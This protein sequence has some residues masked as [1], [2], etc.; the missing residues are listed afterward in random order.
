MAA[1]QR[2]ARTRVTDMSPA[3]LFLALR[4]ADLLGHVDLAMKPCDPHDPQQLW[5]FP[6]NHGLGYAGV[7]VHQSTKLCLMAGGCGDSSGTPLVLDECTAACLASKPLAGKFKLHHKSS[8]PLA[9]E[10]QFP[11][12]LVADASSA[13]PRVVLMEWDAKSNTHQQWTTAMPCEFAMARVFSLPFVAPP[14]CKSLPLKSAVPQTRARTTRCRSGRARTVVDTTTVPNCHLLHPE[15]LTLAGI[16]QQERESV[17][18]DS[19]HR[20]VSGGYPPFCP[21]E[22]CCLSVHIDVVPDGDGG[23]LLAALILSGAVTYLAGGVVVG[24]LSQRPTSGG[25]GSGIRRLAGS[26]PHFTQLEQLGGLCADGLQFTVGMALQRGQ[27][28]SRGGS[29]SASA[30]EP[31]RCGAGCPAGKKKA[32]SKEK[33]DRGTSSGSDKKALGKQKIAKGHDRTA[34]DGKS[35]GNGGESASAPP[36]PMDV[37]AAA[38]GSAAGGGGRWVHVTM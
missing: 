16:F 21:V 2:V 1:V 8:E 38:V 33:D 4:G 18:A 15:S 28:P 12:K 29:G 14:R 26:H 37:A 20:C 17:S 30:R 13:S 7:I 22:P 10:S 34:G 24:K 3:L 5:A 11:N 36:A 35:G 31:L 9:L 23:S 27:H 25:G 6:A 19:R 32:K